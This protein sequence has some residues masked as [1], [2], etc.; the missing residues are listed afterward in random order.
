[1]H[2]VQDRDQS[3]WA[4]QAQHGQITGLRQ[5]RELPEAEPKESVKAEVGSRVSP[6]EIR[7][8][9]KLET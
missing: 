3:D 6:S 4:E 7:C 9:M 2:A 1:M 8:Q 5:R